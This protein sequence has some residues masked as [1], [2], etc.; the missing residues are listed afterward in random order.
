MPDIQILHGDVAD[1]LTELPPKSTDFVHCDAPFAYRSFSE[2]RHGAAAAHYPCLGPDVIA[3]HLSAA[4]RVTKD[5]SYLALWLPLP[6]FSTWGQM[7]PTIQEGGWRY[8]S[9]LSWIKVGGLGMGY[10]VRNDAELCLLLAKGNPRPYVPARSNVL[11]APRQQV[12]SQKPTQA[13]TYLLELATQEGDTVLDMYCGSGSM[14]LAC[15][16]LRRRYVG[17]EI[18]ESRHA[19]ALYRLSLPEQSSLPLQLEELIERSA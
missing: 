13:L 6:H 17:S 19:A 11:R 5:H 15:R 14:A 12:H 7:L 18:D 1:L 9:G 8:L 4:Y 3:A 16:R 10:H 2:A